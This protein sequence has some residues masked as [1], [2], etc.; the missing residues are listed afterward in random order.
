[1]SSYRDLALLV[2]RL[3]S[4]QASSA[5]P[6]DADSRIVASRTGRS[7]LFKGRARTPRRS[8]G[9]AEVAMSIAMG[10]GPV[11]QDRPIYAGM[12]WLGGKSFNSLRLVSD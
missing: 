7:L 8:P 6:N 5:L 11:L 2:I 3:A 4:A 1:V 9:Q 10:R 12:T